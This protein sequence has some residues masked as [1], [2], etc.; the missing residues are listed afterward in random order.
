MK[1]IFT[2]KKI[3]GHYKPRDERFVQMAKLS[4]LS[5]SRFYKTKLYT[6]TYGKYFFE[7]RGIKF[8]EVEILESIDKYKGGL[9]VIPKIYTLLEQTE[10]YIHINLETIIFEVSILSFLSLSIASFP[11]SSSPNLEI[12]FTFPPNLETAMA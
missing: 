7:S 12:K 10:P 6:D 5:A 3:D 8:D 11:Y 2:F 4:V 9:E 1:A